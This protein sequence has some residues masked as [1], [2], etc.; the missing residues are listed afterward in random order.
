VKL[1]DAS[2]NRPIGAKQ[3]AGLTRQKENLAGVFTQEL[4]EGAKK[5]TSNGGQRADVDG[6]VVGWTSTAIYS[7]I[8]KE[9]TRL[10]V[11]THRTSF[12]TSLL[13]FKGY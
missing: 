12:P 1:V 13:S 7:L 10:F 6:E 11:N 5:V 2:T 8:I 3:K 9:G 4:K